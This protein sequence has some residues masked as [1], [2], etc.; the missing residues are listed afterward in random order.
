[1]LHRKAQ[2]YSLPTQQVRSNRRCAINRIQ[3]TTVDGTRTRGALPFL[4]TAHACTRVRAITKARLIAGIDFLVSASA[5][6][7]QISPR[8]NATQHAAMRFTGLLAFAS[9]TRA[10]IH[11]GRQRCRFSSRCSSPQPHNYCNFW[12][13]SNVLVDKNPFTNC[14]ITSR[15]WSL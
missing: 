5:I 11:H 3:R 2:Y 15:F 9:F 13:T 1:M 10:G 14:A 12:H 8:R 4:T 7:P 6:M